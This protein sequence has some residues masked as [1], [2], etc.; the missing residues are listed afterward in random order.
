[1]ADA[2]AQAA[3]ADAR[4]DGMDLHLKA[5]L[6]QAK[7]NHDIQMKQNDKIAALEKQLEEAKYQGTALAQ[8]Q[9]HQQMGVCGNDMTGRF[10]AAKDCAASAMAAL[11]ALELPQA[12]VATAIVFCKEGLLCAAAA[13]AGVRAAEQE[14]ASVHHAIADEYY[15]ARRPS[16]KRSAAALDVTNLDEIFAVNKEA[17]KTAKKRVMNGGRFDPAPVPVKPSFPPPPNGG[18]PAGG[19]PP[20]RPWVPYR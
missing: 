5:M 4:L 14:P 19:V 20:N 3:A 17:H 2:V 8:V 12:D 13:I 6:A 11:T 15:C 10:D 1:M 16:A 18:R 7:S 9:L